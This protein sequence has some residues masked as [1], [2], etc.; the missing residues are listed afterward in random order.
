MGRARQRLQ[1]SAEFLALSDP[2]TAVFAANDVMASGVID[3]VTDLGLR[4]PEDVSVVG[5]DDRDMARFLKP[6]HHSK[7]AHGGDRIHRGKNA[8][9]LRRAGRNAYRFG[10]CTLQAHYPRLMR[11]EQQVAGARASRRQQGT[12]NGQQILVPASCFL[13]L[14]REV[15]LQRLCR[16]VVFSCTVKLRPIKREVSA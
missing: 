15:I 11:G 9:R 1:G 13:L 12:R 5:Y 10:L 2:P 3:A 16:V 6:P 7:A 8:H 4:V 14:G